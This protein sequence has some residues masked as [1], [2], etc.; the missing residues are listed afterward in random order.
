MYRFTGFTQKANEA[1]NN[2]ITSAENLGHT[3]IGSEHLLA[4]LLK[5]EG[6]VANTALTSRGITFE[7]T[8]L[9]TTSYSLLPKRLSILFNTESIVPPVKK[10]NKTAI[11]ALIKSPTDIFTIA[12]MLN[13]HVLSVS[14]MLGMLR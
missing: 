4:G 12:S 3:Y 1:L 2:A 9:E 7:K 14:M 10:K 8:E 6:S 5:S 13:K 11:V